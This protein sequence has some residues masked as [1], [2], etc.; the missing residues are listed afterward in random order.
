MDPDDTETIHITI[1]TIARVK[2]RC[3]NNDEDEP[4]RAAHK[5]SYIITRTV[6]LSP[7]IGA[8]RA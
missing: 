4:S 1:D 7:V 5:K 2:E 3:N 6:D 8:K